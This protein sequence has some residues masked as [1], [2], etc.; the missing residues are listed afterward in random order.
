[1][2]PQEIAQ[3]IDHTLLKAEATAS[4]IRRLCAEAVE[5]G[6]YA[7]CVNSRF[8]ELCVK[9]L[10][11]TEVRVASV[12]GFPLGAM[13]TRSKTFE[14]LR[15]V[16][17]GAHEIDMVLPIGA[18]KAGELDEVAQ[19]IS[20]VV[21][22]APLAKV[23]VILETSLLTD[24]EKRVACRIA[25]EQGAAFVKTS[26]GFGGGGATLADVRL[27]KDVVGDRCGIKASGGIRD[28]K[29]AQDFLKAGATRLGTSSGVAILKGL[30]TQGG[31]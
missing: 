1:M 17:M 24:E 22:A 13:D 20:S 3:R 27:M 21:K 10:K 19:D 25:R 9:E 8:V 30:S 18:L 14:T 7:V 31:Y 29:A 4:E 5:N 26:T 11:G 12:V 15:V 2:T 16:E 28:L 23:K 6:F